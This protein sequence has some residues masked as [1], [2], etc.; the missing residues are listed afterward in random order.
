MRRNEISGGNVKRPLL[1]LVDLDLVSRKTKRLQV[2]E[3][4]D[5]S[6]DGICL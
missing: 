2:E 6:N 4:E 1:S 5:N 3:S